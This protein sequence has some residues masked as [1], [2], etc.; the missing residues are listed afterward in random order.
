VSIIVAG[1]V[2]DASAAQCGQRAKCTAG[3]ASARG[4]QP[5]CEETIQS[6]QTDVEQIGAR[7][8]RNKNAY[9][10]SLT[11]LEESVEALCQELRQDAS[12]SKAILD[13]IAAVQQSCEALRRQ[14]ST[15]FSHSEQVIIKFNSLVR[16]CGELEQRIQVIERQRDTAQ[17]G[18]IALRDRI[19]FLSLLCDHIALFR[20][21]MISQLSYEIGSWQELAILLAEEASA[22]KEGGSTQPGPVTQ[23]LTTVLARH[24]FTWNDWENLRVVADAS[25]KDYHT[26][27]LMGPGATIK[28]IESGSLKVPSAFLTT[29]APVKKML[30]Y[31]HAS[32]RPRKKGV[33]V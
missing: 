27:C 33:A 3:M 8:L 14:A 15:V 30:Q 21:K 17:N 31:V 22:A 9:T 25:N 18:E 6:L 16:V 26:G 11:A 7:L 23:D 24:C 2:F 29:V 13:L 5:S 20:T 4:P 12:N 10:H 28:A 32:T 1:A 19:A